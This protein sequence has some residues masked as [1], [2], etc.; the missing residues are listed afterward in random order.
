MSREPEAGA[1]WPGLRRVF[2]L[3]ANQ[4]RV[5]DEVTD[6][7]WFH[8]EERIEEFMGKGLSREEA[9]AEVRR[10][11]GDI[12][13]VGDELERIDSTTQRRRW[14]GEWLESVGRD[15]RYALGFVLQLWFYATPVV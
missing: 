8:I 5:R 12:G 2:R 4:R 6:E 15:V 10:R 3:P 1:G 13:R 9:E 11:F 14:R 7:L